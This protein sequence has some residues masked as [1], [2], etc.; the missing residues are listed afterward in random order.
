MLRKRLNRLTGT[1]EVQE[2]P[3]LASLRRFAH[4]QNARLIVPVS[5]L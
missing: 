5:E 2:V 3:E 4:S 1:Y